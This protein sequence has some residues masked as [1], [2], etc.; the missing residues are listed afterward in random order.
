MELNRNA[1]EGSPAL[2]FMMGKSIRQKI[3]KD[4]H[5]QAKK[6]EVVGDATSTQ[7]TNVDSVGGSTTDL[8]NIG[9]DITALEQYGITP[10]IYEKYKKMT[11]QQKEEQYVRVGMPHIKRRKL[12][13]KSIELFPYC[14]V[15]YFV[16]IINSILSEENENYGGLRSVLLK[17]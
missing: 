15:K 16:P 13:F 14:I 7:T 1:L 2:K 4:S 17:F 11:D 9:E 5:P 8:F 6:N 12:H 10:T 3:I